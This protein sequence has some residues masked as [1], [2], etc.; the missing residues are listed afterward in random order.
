MKYKNDYRF[1]EAY[2]YILYLP[3]IGKYKI[4]IA[5]DVEVRLKQLKKPIKLLWTSEIMKRF[6]AEYIESLVLYTKKRNIVYGEYL[7]SGNTEVFSSTERSIKKLIN[8]INN[9]VRK[10]GVYKGIRN[11]AYALRWIRS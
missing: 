10:L 2:I 6:D 11:S 4:G 8:S 9:H 1:S 7:N 3:E 5:K